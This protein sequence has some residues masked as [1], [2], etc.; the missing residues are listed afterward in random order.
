MRGEIVKSV[1][2]NT[3]P[4]VVSVRVTDEQMEDIRR[5]ME[6]TKKSASDVMREAFALFAEKIERAERLKAIRAAAVKYSGVSKGAE[7]PSRRSPEQGAA[8]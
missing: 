8:P 3:R 7:S 6:A 5:L 1:Y 2:T 4:S